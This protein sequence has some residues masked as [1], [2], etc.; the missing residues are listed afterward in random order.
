MRG[1]QG[2]NLADWDDDDDEGTR[3]S[4]NLSKVTRMNPF[5]VE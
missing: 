3:L 1:G 5:C 4:Y 2:P